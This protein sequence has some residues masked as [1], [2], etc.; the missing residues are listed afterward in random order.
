MAQFPE[1]VYKLYQSPVLAVDAPSLA[2]LLAAGWSATPVAAPITVVRN[3][4]VASQKPGEQL[5]EHVVRVTGALPQY[6]LPETIILGTLAIVYNGLELTESIDFTFDGF[7]LVSFLTNTPA[8]GDVLK[9]KYR[10]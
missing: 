6:M 5:R 3:A 7:A 10:F 1:L 9:F 4:I 2:A 8:N